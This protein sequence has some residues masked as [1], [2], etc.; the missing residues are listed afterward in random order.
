MSAPTQKIVAVIVTYRPN[1]ELLMRNFQALAPQVAEI[2]VVD[3]SDD[4]TQAESV[5][6]LFRGRERVHYLWNQG[7]QGIAFAL[8]AGVRFAEQLGADWVLTMDQDSVLPD[9]YVAVLAEDAQAYGDRAVSIG[10]PFVS[11]SHRFADT[12]SGG[13][14]KLLITSGNLIRVDAVK[15][16]G[17]FRDEFFI[18]YVDFDLS[19]RLRK[20]GYLLIETHRISFNHQLGNATRKT[21]FGKTFSCTNYSPLR[22]Y[23]MSRNRIVFFKENI[24]F[25]PS[26]VFRCAADMCKEALKMLIGEDDRKKKMT[27][28]LSGIRDGLLGRM[29]KY[30]GRF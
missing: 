9:R 25:D 12:S 17:Y 14:V 21:L 27:A 10:T 3:N 20:L 11:A 24:W 2:V 26:L 4:A 23:Y 30:N 18:D 22:F 29:G 16:A 28:I 15:Q 1:P 19:L 7:N 5:R 13:P 8:S 6:Q